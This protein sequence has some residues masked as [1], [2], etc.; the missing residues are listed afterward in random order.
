MKDRELEQENKEIAVFL[1][2]DLND[3]ELINQKINEHI[4]ILHEYNELKDIV[5]SILGRLA[6]VEGTT[7]KQMYIKYGL[8]IND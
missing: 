2:L 4:R 7:T 3:A 8:E 1:G 6:E 5:Q